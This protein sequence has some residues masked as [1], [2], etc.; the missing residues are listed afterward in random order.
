MP[1]FRSGEIDI[2]FKASA[3]PG[4]PKLLYISGTGGDLRKKPGIFDSALPEFFQLLSFDQ[5]GLGRSGKPDRSYSMT[6]YAQD[7]LR[8]LDHVGWD[9][10]QVMGVSFG[11]MVAQ[12]LAINHSE[13]IE[14]LVLCCTSS[15]GDGGSSYPLHE[16]ETLNELERAKKIIAISDL[17]CT[18]QWIASNPEI[19]AEMLEETLAAMRFAADEENHA[20]GASRQLQAR[21]HHNT[22]DRLSAITCPTLVCGGKYDGLSIPDNLKVLAERIPSTTLEFFEGGHM[23]LLQDGRAFPKI[24]DYL[25]RQ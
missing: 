7:A 1:F 10:A 24:I 20:L 8:L 25:H 12:E 16:L 9:R 19:Y 5:R 21:K 6:D 3:P 18:P 11:G 13:R 15:G 4:R 23:F 17:R 2:Y 14:R 22:Y